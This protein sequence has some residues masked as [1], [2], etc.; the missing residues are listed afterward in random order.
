MSNRKVL[1][2]IGAFSPHQARADIRAAEGQA[3][4]EPV[5]DHLR[6]R[7]ETYGIFARV[8]YSALMP[9]ALM[10]G[11]HRPISALCK[12]ARPSGDC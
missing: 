7:I 3:G 8:R 10:I 2:S 4:L 5:I 12:L 1:P 9:A 11:H 6:S